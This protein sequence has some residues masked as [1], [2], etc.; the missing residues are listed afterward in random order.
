MEGGRE[1]MEGG[2]RQRETDKS[3]EL[4]E[5]NT[6]LHHAVNTRIYLQISIA[7]NDLSIAME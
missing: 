1:G 3:N 6:P 5:A 2:E 4:K 7:S